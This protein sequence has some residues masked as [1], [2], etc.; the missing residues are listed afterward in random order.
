MSTN[1]TTRDSQRSQVYAA[2][3][4]LRRMLDRQF[5][6]PTVSI[7]GSTL[8]LPTE[9]KFADLDSIQRYVSTISPGLTVRERKADSHAHYS[10]NTIAIPLM[11]TRTGKMPW[12]AREIVVLHEVAHH[13]AQGD[14]HGPAFTQAFLDLV[15]QQM[16]PEAQFLLRVLFHQ[17]GVR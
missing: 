12:A 1:T 3:Q 10:Q 9:L 4:E 11:R 2:E 16:G 8:T 5:D 7:A 13:L 14:Q 6:F 15:L 17:E